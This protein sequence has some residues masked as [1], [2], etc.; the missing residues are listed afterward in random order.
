MDR[1]KRLLKRRFVVTFIVTTCLYF[2]FVIVITGRA[3]MTLAAGG[4]GLVVGGILGVILLVG[5]ILGLRV[6]TTQ[7]VAIFVAR[8]LKRP[9]E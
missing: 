8:L 5:I 2:V 6:A 7:W 3:L 9:F 1:L 4:D